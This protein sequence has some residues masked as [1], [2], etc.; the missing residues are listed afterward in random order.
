MPA[1]R[2]AIRL[3]NTHLTLDVWT[4]SRYIKPIPEVISSQPLQTAQ[5][6]LPVIVLMIPTATDAGAMVNVCG[7]TAMPAM[8]GL[9]SLTAS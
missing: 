8:I 2:P 4:S 9:I 3:M 1:P 6:N 7:K 5:R